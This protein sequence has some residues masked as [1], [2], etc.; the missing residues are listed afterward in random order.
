MDA[1]ISARELS[2]FRKLDAIIGSAFIK[3]TFPFFVMIIVW[4]IVVK[5]GVFPPT[6][7]TGPYEVG[8]KLITL[9]RQGILTAYLADSL[10]R[11][12]VGSLTALAIGIPLGYLIGLNKFA[13]R[14]LTPV[15]TFFQAVSDIAWLPILIIWFGFTLTTVNIILIYSIIFPVMLSIVAGVDSIKGDL[16]RAGRSLG[17]SRTQILFEIILPG[18]FAFV[19]TGIRT[20]LG[21]GWRA[22]IGTEIIVGTSGVGFLMF[23]GRRDGDIS[24]VLVCMIVLAVLWHL[25]D[26]FILA[27]IERNTV[28]RWGLINK[29]G[30]K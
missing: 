28:E 7:F 5:A 16:V 22:L 4:W 3:S 23:E 19:A 11:L 18:S 20:G 2:V 29:V 14:A 8:E 25:T 1:N 12:L 15:I 10:T 13:R 21:Y 24:V 9:I 30:K 26:T 6:F 17:A 27:P